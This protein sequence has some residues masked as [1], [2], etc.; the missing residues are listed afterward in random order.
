MRKILLLYDQTFSIKGCDNIMCITLILNYMRKI[1]NF[2]TFYVFVIF[3]DYFWY[4]KT[5]S[6]RF[7]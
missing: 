7:I 1:Q 3:L 4:S 6:I 5:F 2:Y